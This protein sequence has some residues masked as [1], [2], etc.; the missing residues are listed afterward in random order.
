MKRD[1]GE[2]EPFGTVLPN[3]VPGGLVY[4]HSNWL[5]SKQGH[6]S[7]NQSKLNLAYVGTKF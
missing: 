2:G 6:P 7:K 4:S 3:P 5:I 1:L